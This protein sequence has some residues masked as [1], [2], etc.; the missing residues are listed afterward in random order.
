[1]QFLSLEAAGIIA[2]S[3]FKKSNCL[4]VTYPIF[5]RYL[6]FQL[7]KATATYQDQPEA[8]NLL[9]LFNLIYNK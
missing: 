6:K 7:I 3:N 4:F 9:Q 5:F 1:M 8:D 2:W